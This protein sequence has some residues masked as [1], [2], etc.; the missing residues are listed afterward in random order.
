MIGKCVYH[1]KKCK[2]KILNYRP[3]LI[4]YTLIEE[5]RVV[6]GVITHVCRDRLIQDPRIESSTGPQIEFYFII[7]FFC[8]FFLYTNLTNTHAFCTYRRV[9]GLCVYHMKKCKKK[10]QTI[11][12]PLFLYTLIE[13]LRVVKGLG[14]CAYHMKKCKKTISNY[15]P[16]L[17]L[18]ILIEELRVVKGLV[19]YGLGAD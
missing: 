16:S 13:E 17:I 2:K 12:H 8:V 9:I 19:T 1:I 15:R 7:F 6:K 10:F 3:S 14:K 18:Y 4:L 11:D 5:L